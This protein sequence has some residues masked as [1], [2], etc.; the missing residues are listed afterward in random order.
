MNFSK[1]SPTMLPPISS[2]LQFLF[3][4]FQN[5]WTSPSHSQQQSLSSD[6]L[7]SVHGHKNITTTIHPTQ[8]NEMDPICTAAQRGNEEIWTLV[9]QP[10]GKGTPWK[11]E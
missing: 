10:E 11:T 5:I 6:V 2:N 9:R 4:L 7:Y 8:A 3:M 1:N